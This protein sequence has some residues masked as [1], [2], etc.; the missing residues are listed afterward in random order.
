MGSYNKGWISL[1][2]GQGVA[3]LAAQE[4]HVTDLAQW[5]AFAGLAALVTALVVLV[6][7]R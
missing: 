3:W 6:P 4:G 2:G 7:N 1:L 5:L